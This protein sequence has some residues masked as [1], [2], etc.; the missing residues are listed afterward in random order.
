MVNA[1]IAAIQPSNTNMPATS[2]SAGTPVPTPAEDLVRKTK[3]RLQL[4]EMTKNAVAQVS[5]AV[6]VA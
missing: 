1:A 2:F 6:S 4:T 3:Q 5:R